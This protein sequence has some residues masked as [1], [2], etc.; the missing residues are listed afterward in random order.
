MGTAGVGDASASS[1]PPRL[2]RCTPKCAGGGERG[3]AEGVGIDA[4]G[5]GDASVSS[6]SPRHRSCIIQFSIS[7]CTFCRGAKVAG[8]R[9]WGWVQQESKILDGSEFLRDYLDTIAAF[10]TVGAD[11]AGVGDPLASPGLPRHCS[12]SLSLHSTVGTC[13]GEVRWLD[14]GSGVGYSRNWGSLSFP[15]ITQTPSPQ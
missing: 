13:A 9:E 8:Q 10:A 7:R 14:R 12:C 11:L 15:K 3:W 5:V 4:A 1:R 2:L 6:A